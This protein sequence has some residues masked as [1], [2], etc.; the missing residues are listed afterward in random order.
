MIRSYK[1]LIVWQDG[2]KL[3]LEIFK[4]TSKFPATQTYILTSQMLRAAISITSNIA[5][6]FTRHSNME[7]KQFYFISKGSLIEVDNQLLIAK[8]V[9]YINEEKYLEIE[10]Q[11]EYVNRL[12]RGLII[13]VSKLSNSC[14]L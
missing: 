9:G 14:S 5:E 13:G 6:G 10:N 7:K 4:I 3:V 1:D 8:D 11:V 12:L 2:H